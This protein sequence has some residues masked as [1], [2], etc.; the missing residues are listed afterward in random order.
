MG[1]I[2]SRRGMQA[3]LAL[4]IGAAPA[5]GCGGASKTCRH[6]DGAEL[7]MIEEGR[8][9]RFA[10]S[11]FRRESDVQVSVSD[12]VHPAQPGMPTRT[13]TDGSFPEG[14]VLSVVKGS[15][16]QSVTVT[17]TAS[18]GA[19]VRFEFTVPAQAG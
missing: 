7:C 9:Y 18:T 14:G 13:D 8:S 12:D 19:P 3:A 4:V 6:L 5:S 2:G 17:G 1:N 15:I 10:G 16:P 11:G